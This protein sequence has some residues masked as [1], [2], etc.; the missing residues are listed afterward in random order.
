MREIDPV[1]SMQDS[2]QNTPQALPD[3]KSAL[4]LPPPPVLGPYRLEEKLGRGGMGEVFKALDERLD[5]LVALKLLYGEED[6]LVARFVRE[7]RAQA[8]VDHQHICQIYEAGELEGRHFI[9]MQYLEGETLDIALEGCS[10]EEKITLLREIALAL[11]AAHRQGLVHRDIK[12]NNVI[13]TR[14]VRGRLKPFVV[15]FGLACESTS[16]ITP[17]N[18]LMGTPQYMAPEQLGGDLDKIDRRTDV[19]SFGVT[20][21]QILT[22]HPP[23]KGAFG[24]L[25]RQVLETEAPTLRSIAPTMPLDLETIVAK[26]LEKNPQNR[27]ESARA[28]ADDLDRYLAGEPIQ[29]RPMSFLGKLGKKARKY[30]LTVS[31]GVVGLTALLGALAWGAHTRWTADRTARLAQTFGSKV[32]RIEALARYSQM[33]PLHDTTADMESLRRQ[34]GEIE[35]DMESLGKIGLGPGNDAL[36]RGYLVL[37]D[38]ARAKEHLERAAAIGNPNPDTSLA[39]GRA[40]GLLYQQELRELTRID[41][42]GERA[43]RRQRLDVELR[44]PAVEALRRSVGAALAHSDLLRAEL[45]FYGGELDTAIE[46]ARAAVADI[47]WLYEARVLEGRA[48]FRRANELIERG[49]YDI[50]ETR[51][52]EARDAFSAALEIGRSHLPA[53][54][55]DCSAALPLLKLEVRGRGE[56]IDDLWQGGVEAC[57]KALTAGP[58]NPVVQEVLAGLHY[59]YGEGLSIRGEDPLPI[60]ERSLDAARKALA[61]RPKWPLPQIQIGNVYAQIGFLA[62]RRGADPTAGLE[63]AA[64]ALRGAIDLDP[65]LSSSHGN[66]G[67]VHLYLAIHRLERSEEIEPVLREA[68]TAYERAIDLE[69]GSSTYFNNLGIVHLLLGDEELRHGTDPRPSVDRALDVFAQAGEI[70]P[71]NAFVHANVGDCHRLRAQFEIWTEQVPEASIRAALAAY[72]RTLEIHIR[73]APALAASGDAHRMH[74]EWLL[75]RG[76]DPSLAVNEGIR[77]VEAALEINPRDSEPLVIRAQLGLL[78]ARRRLAKGSTVDFTALEA[79]AQRAIEVK[80]NSGDAW[81]TLAKVHHLADRPRRGLEAVAKALEAAPRMAEAQAVDGVLRLALARHQQGEEAAESRRLGR[82]SLARALQQNP[83]LGSVYR[84]EGT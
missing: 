48:Q 56:R 5:R 14:G 40:L 15:D 2:A 52:H 3:H 62:M 51:L 36:G 24:A 49:E 4:Y 28:L 82:A 9:A 69:P 6:E 1:L 74:A 31:V 66:L 84:E 47:P 73:Y 34:M 13:V 55:S 80:S 45:A 42:E 10:L 53:L 67:N 8:S 21:F 33:L 64:E 54:E 71:N 41:D 50:A 17:D 32:E 58:E 27:Y 30:R 61:S 43:R 16:K 79:L 77:A 60:Y 7:A 70:N 11:H 63:A 38:G 19:Y 37:G 68:I 39:L 75:R 72:E 83:F 26:C 18:D 22:G 20:M 23:F 57:E 59:R 76:K 44:D 81:L 46:A 25:L 12:P 78:D 35:R 29:A 65:R